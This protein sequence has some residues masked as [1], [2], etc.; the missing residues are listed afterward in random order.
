LAKEQPFKEEVMSEP[1]YGAGDHELSH[2]ADF[3]KAEPLGWKPFKPSESGPEARVQSDYG[4]DRLTQPAR[5]IQPMREERSFWSKTSDEIRSWFGDRKAEARR[6]EDLAR[7]YGVGAHD[8]PDDDDDVVWHG[9][10]N[11][12]PPR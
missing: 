5:T 1:R 12:P 8:A 7:E 6:T 11:L 2:R 10:G 4:Y 9:E 3:P